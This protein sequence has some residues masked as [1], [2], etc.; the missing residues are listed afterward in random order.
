MGFPLVIFR[1]YKPMYEI[2]Q[3]I[4]KNIFTIDNFL[5]KY[6]KLTKKLLK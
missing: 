4:F 5:K 2:W 1:V 6:L 3:P